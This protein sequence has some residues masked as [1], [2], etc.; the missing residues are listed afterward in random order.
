[1]ETASMPRTPE[2]ANK[3]RHLALLSEGRIQL[4]SVSLVRPRVGR[5]SFDVGKQQFASSQR[6]AINAHLLTVALP[7]FFFQCTLPARLA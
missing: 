6:A 4:K 2:P 1:M 7:N 3:S 5:R